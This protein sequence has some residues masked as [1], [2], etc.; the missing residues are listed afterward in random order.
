M[1]WADVVEVLPDEDGEAALAVN[2][3]FA[4][5]PEMVLGEHGRTSSPFGPVYTCRACVGV[6]VE[7][8]LGRALEALSEASCACR[9]T[10]VRGRPSAQ[11]PHALW[12]APRPRAPR[13]RRAATS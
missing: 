7:A 3:Y 10:G 12:W 1:A 13:S 6:D 4:E 2:R 9:V 11:V 8:A 5:H